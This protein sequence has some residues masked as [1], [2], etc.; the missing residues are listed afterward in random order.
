M[1]RENET[2][3]LVHQV[4]IALK[5][6]LLGASGGIAVY[7]FLFAKSDDKDK[8][9]SI[10]MILINMV[11]GAFVA[12]AVGS[13][14]P[15]DMVGRSGLLGFAGAS[16]FKIMELVESRLANSLYE[17]LTGKRIEEE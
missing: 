9:F 13:F 10:S 3:Q 1:I 7:L 6:V 16:A 11:V 8:H 17:K 15:L 5:D 2:L 12:G 4:L 14:L